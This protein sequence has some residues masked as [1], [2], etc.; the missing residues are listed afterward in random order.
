LDFC[1]KYKF[2]QEIIEGQIKQIVSEL[3]LKR[4]DININDYLIA[5]EELIAYNSN[6]SDLFIN[7]IFFMKQLHETLDQTTLKPIDNIVASP[8]TPIS[9]IILFILFLIVTVGKLYG[10]S[11]GNGVK[12]STK[13][14]PEVYNMF[15]KMAQRV[16][17]EKTPDIILINGNGVLNAFATTMP[18]IRNIVVIHSDIFE[19]CIA[20]NDMETLSFILGHE[21]GHIK[22]NHT[23]WWYHIVTAGLL[24]IPGVNLLFRKALSRANEYSCDK[25]GALLSN[26]SSGRSLMILSA[27]KHNY[28]DVD[29]KQYMNDQEKKNIWITISN[30][31]MD[32]PI[33]S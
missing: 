33:I 21:L 10:Y 13:Q 1:N 8:V 16:G 24:F 12:L 23:K 20:N 5:I 3:L 26:D 6:Y 15:E 7:L 18:M 30:F 4:T 17:L 25:L 32:H 2:S 19:K 9:I 29:I 14:F 22:F 27:G 31:S 28:R 11:L